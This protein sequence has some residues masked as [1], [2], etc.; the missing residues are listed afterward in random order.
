M[1]STPECVR[2]PPSGA[3]TDP[4]RRRRG[5]GGPVT[6]N[7]DGPAPRTRHGELRP[8]LI[9]P[10]YGW[11]RGGWGKCA[12]SSDGQ[13]PL[14]ALL[15]VLWRSG[16]TDHHHG[17]HTAADPGTG[18]TCP[19]GGPSAAE[20]P[21]DGCPARG[22]AQAEQASSFDLTREYDF[23][24]TWRDLAR[25]RGNASASAAHGDGAAGDPAADPLTI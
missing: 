6:G 16:G 24:F 22:F 17:G 15:D 10:Y 3:V 25:V 9:S 23:S 20:R 18:R 19:C 7:G 4:Y 12:R 14:D 5:R 2:R 13:R 1:A 8:R 11:I 21:G